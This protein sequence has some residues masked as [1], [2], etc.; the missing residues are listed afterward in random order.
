[1]S[2]HIYIAALFTLII[3]DSRGFMFNPIP[4]TSCFRLEPNDFSNIQQSES[5]YNF[6][7][8][9]CSNLLTLFAVPKKRVSKMKGRKRHAVWSRKA[10]RISENAFTLGCSIFSNIP[11][12]PALEPPTPPTGPISSTARHVKKQW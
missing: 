1:M 4:Y 9:S 11:N 8:E 7:P 3:P 6:E 5:A 12:N 2:K 10:K